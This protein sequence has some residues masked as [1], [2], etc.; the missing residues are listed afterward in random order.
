[1]HIFSPPSQLSLFMSSHIADFFY[2]FGL[3]FCIDGP[4]LEYFVFQKNTGLDI[5]CSLTVNFDEPKKQI[6]VMTFFPGLNLHPETHY[7]SAVCF[8]MVM[9]HFAN[10]HHIKSDCTISLNTKQGVFDTFYALL[11][12]FDF[13]MLLTG[14]ND[15][16]D[17]ESQLNYMVTDTSMFAKRALILD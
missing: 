7:F 16:V 5:S 17:I 11:Q 8:Y 4:Q 10:F 15:H 3:S 6:N 9:H 12:D 14:Q 1:M 13:H 2:R